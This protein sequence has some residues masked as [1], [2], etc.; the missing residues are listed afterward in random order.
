MKA[1]GVTACI[2]YYRGRRY[3][4]RAVESLLGQTHRDLQVIVV[5][6]GD[7]DPPWDQLSQ[8]RDRRLVLFNLTRNHG[9]PFFA[10]AV[11]AEAT[12]SAWFLVQ[13]QD[14]WSAP[15][16]LERLIGLAQEQGADLAVSAQCFHREEADG[17]STA[18]G[19]RWTHVGRRVCPVCGLDSNC[20]RCFV[21]LALTSNYRY[22]APHAALI[23][24]KLLQ[25]IG[26]YYA[27]LHLHY[28]SLLMNLLMM[29]GR[30]AHTGDPLYHR[31]LRP[32]SITHCSSTGFGSEA[33]KR[34]HR[35]VAELY[36]WFFGE[37]QLYLRGEID[38]Q[39][40]SRQ[41]RRCC[42][43]QVTPDERRELRQETERLRTQLAANEQGRVH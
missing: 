1:P 36:K 18:V 12:S 34:E 8:V 25:S 13:E 3:I 42:E 32:D 2:P 27:G 35:R 33:S 4:R 23:R 15:A 20:Q 43:A 29:T 37:Y 21:D 39:A 7:P 30:L 41:V 26:G 28:D 14:D 9:G 16:R 17:S 10:N 6:D 5:N 40:F 38:S 24:V 22:R 19:L 31:L 11:V